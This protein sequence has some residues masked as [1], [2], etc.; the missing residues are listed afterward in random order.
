M[1][2]E[3]PRYDGDLAMQCYRLC[4]DLF[5]RKLGAGDLPVPASAT[6]AVGETKH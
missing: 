4:V 6:A 2:D 3:G 1:R 5:R